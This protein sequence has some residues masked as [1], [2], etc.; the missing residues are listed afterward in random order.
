LQVPVARPEERDRDRVAEY[1]LVRASA[2]F[3]FWEQERP[4]AS[5]DVELAEAKPTLARICWVLR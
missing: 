1:E 3:R 5:F 2:A 4:L